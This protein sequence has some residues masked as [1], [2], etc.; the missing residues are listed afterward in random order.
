V[1]LPTGTVTFVLGDVAGSSRLWE[2]HGDRMASALAEL[3]ALVDECIAGRE[4]GRPLEQG[5]G[6]SFVA[7]FATATDALGFALTLQQE[8]DRRG[9]DGVALRVRLGVHTG[10]ALVAAGGT[11]RGEALNRCGRLRALASGG[12]VLVSGTTS[13]LVVGHLADGAWLEDLGVHRLRDLARAERVHELRHETLRAEFPPLVS[14]DGLATNLPVQL[15]SFVGR[16]REMDDL[17]ALL[18]QARLVTLTGAGGAGKTRLAMQV[19]AEGVGSQTGEAWLVDFAPVVDPALLVAAVAGALGVSEVP[20]Q[21][22]DETLQARLAE[23]HALLVFDNCEHL[24]EAVRDLAES[25]L[26]TCPALTVLA[27]SREALGAEGE[28]TYQVMS[29]GLPSGPDDPECDSVRLFVERAALVRPGFRLTAETT[30]PVVE[31]CCRL[32]GIPLAIELAAARCRLLS[33]AQIT[34]QLSDRFALLTGGR[35]SA[36]P[37]QRTLEASVEWSHGLL[38]EDEQRVFRRLSVFAGGWT[39]EAA[40]N[41]CASHGLEAWQIFNALSGLADKSMVVVDA[42][43]ASARYRMLETIRHYAQQRLVES[44]EAPELR[45]RH[46]AY[47]VEVAQTAGAEVRGPTMLATLAALEREIDNLRAADDWTVESNKHDAALRLLGPLEEFWYRR[48]SVEGYRRVCVA[49]AEPGGDPAARARACANAAWTAWNL[50][51]VEGYSAHTAELDELARS[52][53]DERLQ[54]I[55]VDIRA[56]ATMTEADEAAVAMFETAVE[57][58]EPLGEIWYLV[59]ALWGLATAASMNGSYEEACGIAG[60]ALNLS[61]ASGNPMLVC[62]S[63]GALG[64]FEVYRGHF[65]LAEAL[66]DEG[67]ELAEALED[68]LFATY[69]GAFRAWLRDARGDH[70]GATE[71][72]KQALTVA[73]RQQ[74]VPSIALSLFFRGVIEHR[75]RQFDPA[76][77]SFGEAEPYLSLIGTSWAIAWSR[78]L[79]AEAAID[80]G[81]IDVARRQ[82]RDGLRFADAPFARSARPRCFLVAAR[83]AYFRKK[84][85]E[86]EQ[87]AHTALSLDLDAGGC[88]IAIEALELLAR[89]AIEE[90]SAAHGARLLAAAETQRG[91]L[92]YPVPPVEETALA[93]AIEA[94]RSALDDAAFAAAWS[95]GAT[96]TLGEATTSARRGRGEHGRP[97]VS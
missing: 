92:G 33:P 11:Y 40:E 52:L 47:F 86:A 18:D 5:E 24:I 69:F 90:G 57:R 46:L 76:S 91:F 58:L 43:P 67:I 29:L 36:L 10:E 19:A 68:D 42:E 59:D 80:R 44:G 26:R 72:V 61:R 45:D 13:D 50:G 39:L 37:R 22:L 74:C 23:R 38:S 73:T 83:V 41:V 2:Q 1:A 78:A 55:A 89:L 87:Q 15:T 71:L 95:E 96:M 79:L 51:L 53:G 9:F 27:T 94:A 28:V 48:H 64:A 4:G 8:I 82:A 62:R 70:A 12:Q 32:D 85:S 35:H 16:G 77:A 30:A 81:E 49:L 20:F 21:T 34:T 84:P 17:T 93:T 25:L 66:L 14:L 7:A 65:H 60:Q 3:E 88:P 75:D 97:S 31:V 54:A 56:W 6:D 63:A